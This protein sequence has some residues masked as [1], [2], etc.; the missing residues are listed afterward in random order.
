MKELLNKGKTKMKFYSEK[1]NK[2]YEAYI[3]LDITEKYINFKMEF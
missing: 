3:K 1:A 2:D